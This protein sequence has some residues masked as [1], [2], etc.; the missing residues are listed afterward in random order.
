[1]I[2]FFKFVEVCFMAQDISILMGTWK[3]CVFAVLVII[4][5]KGWLDS[6][7]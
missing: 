6:V 1:M 7:V 5:Y 2:Q 3:Q 4:F